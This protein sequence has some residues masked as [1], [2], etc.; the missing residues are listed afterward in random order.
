MVVWAWQSIRPDGLCKRGG[1]MWS[2]MFRASL[3]DY[4]CI[5]IE[6]V[7]DIRFSIYTAPVHTTIYISVLALNRVE[8]SI[9]WEMK[10]MDV[11]DIG[12]VK[13]YPGLYFNNHI[14]GRYEHYVWKERTADTKVRVRQRVSDSAASILQ[15]ALPKCSDRISFQCGWWD[16]NTRWS[17]ILSDTA[18]NHHIHFMTC[19]SFVPTM[20]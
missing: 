13:D 4:L 1:I 18:R 19:R 20:D 17:C 12:E 8:N 7:V 11:C 3:G 5:C 9:L 6:G 2:G 10:I 15:F 16:V 14:G